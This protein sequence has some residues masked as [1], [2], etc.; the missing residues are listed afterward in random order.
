MVDHEKETANRFNEL[1]ERTQVFLSQLRESDIELM[2]EGI[3]LV[4]AIQTVGKFVRWLILAALAIMVGLV[5]LHDNAVKIWAWFH[6][7]K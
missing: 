4:R 7:S 2:E 5:S 1:P 6:V 3:D